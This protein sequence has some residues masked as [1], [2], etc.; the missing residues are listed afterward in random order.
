MSH[1]LA[2]NQTIIPGNY[3]QCTPGVLDSTF[4]TNEK[5]QRVQSV[6]ST[7]STRL[8]GYHLIKD[9]STLNSQS[10]IQDDTDCRESLIL[11]SNLFRSHKAQK[12]RIR[13][14]TQDSL[15]NLF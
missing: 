9:I 11:Y 5:P 4:D 14:L 7:S 2:M 15:I 12:L 8:N 6:E 3:Q 1:K 13:N 10:C